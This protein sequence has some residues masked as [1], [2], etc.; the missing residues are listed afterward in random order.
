MSEY[1]HLPLD[2]ERLQFRKPVNTLQ[3]SAV[4]AFATQLQAAEMG[5]AFLWVR[6]WTDPRKQPTQYAAQS[7]ANAVEET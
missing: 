7:V 3:A 1:L 4:P 2:F 6:L 5:A